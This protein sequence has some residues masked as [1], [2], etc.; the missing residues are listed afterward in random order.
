MYYI[1]H[2]PG[3]KI[4]VS[5]EPEKRVANQGYSDYEILEE[6]TDIYEVSSREIELQKEY[7]YRVDRIP[8]WQSKE[9]FLKASMVSRSIPK[10]KAQLDHMSML[11]KSSTKNIEHQKKAAKSSVQSPNFALRK[12]KVCEYCGKEMRLVNYSRW[13]GDRCKKKGHSEE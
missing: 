9:R 11:G 5:T 1:Y 6:H 3:V 13:H 2:I 4:G 10:S 12:T 8:Y 7:G